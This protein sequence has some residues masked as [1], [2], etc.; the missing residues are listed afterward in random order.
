MSTVV[1]SIPTL[2]STAHRGGKAR[3]PTEPAWHVGL[4]IA[5]TALIALL[6]WRPVRNMASRRQLMNVSFDAL[7]LVKTYGA[8]DDGMT[9]VSQTKMATGRPWRWR[10]SP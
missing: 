2:G 6:S 7:R 9:V 1:G 3:V 5:L 8:F 10:A 4:V